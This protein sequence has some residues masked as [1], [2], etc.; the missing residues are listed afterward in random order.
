MHRGRRS[1]P[2]S[3]FTFTIGGKEFD[4]PY[5]LGD[6]IYPSWGLLALPSGDGDHS[7]SGSYNIRQESRRKDVECAFGCLKERFRILKTGISARDVRSV[8]NVIV[9]CAI[10]HNMVI[11]WKLREGVMNDQSTDQEP[12][13]DLPKDIVQEATVR[14][15]YQQNRKNEKEEEAQ[16]LHAMN[17]MSGYDKKL[18]SLQ[19]HVRLRGALERHHSTELRQGLHN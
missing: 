7:T 17:W 11:D 8:Q 15:D 19:E 12:L 6:G 16:E 14:G 1:I 3:Q 2:T 10:L 13:G 4:H 9:T 5:L 18:L